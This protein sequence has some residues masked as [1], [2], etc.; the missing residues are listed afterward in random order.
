MSA[1]DKK[2]AAA[3]D[4]LKRLPPSKTYT[5]LEVKPPSQVPTPHSR[6]IALPELPEG[7]ESANPLDGPDLLTPPRLSF[8]FPCA[9]LFAS[10]KCLLELV[11]ED[12]AEDL[13]SNV[14]QPL[15][16]AKDSKLGKQY[17]LCDYNRDGD[18]YR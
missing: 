13:L 15:Q 12:V 4:L 2:L 1:D 3:L 9:F 10:L 8:P 17:L 18:S 14:D 5:Y 11:P 7:I 6:R 16:V